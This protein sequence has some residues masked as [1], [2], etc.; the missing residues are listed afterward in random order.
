MLRNNDAAT[1]RSFLVGIRVAYRRERDPAYDEAQISA[2]MKKP[3]IS[4]KVTL[5]LTLGL[6]HGRGG[7]SATISD[8]DI[9]K[10]RNPERIPIRPI[11]MRP[12]ID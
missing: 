6:R 12:G 4:L 2:A 8:R 3:E 7:S 10:T 9:R 11:R 5:G 1:A